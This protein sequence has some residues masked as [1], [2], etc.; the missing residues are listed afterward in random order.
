MRLMY[1]VGVV[2]TKLIDDLLNLFMISSENGIANDFLEP[3]YGPISILWVEE[4]PGRES[5]NRTLELPVFC[6]H[7]ACHSAG[8][9]SNDP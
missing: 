5:V 1:G 3:E 4:F 9:E 2:M 6:D 8:A 7:R